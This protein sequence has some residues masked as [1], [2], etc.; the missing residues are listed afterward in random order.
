MSLSVL[1]NNAW[2]QAAQFKVTDL[3][4]VATSDTDASDNVVRGARHLGYAQIGTG[5]RRFAYVNKAGGMSADTMVLID[6]IKHA[7]H[8]INVKSWTAFPGTSSSHFSSTNWA[9]TLIGPNSRDVLM[10]IGAQSA[11]HGFGIELDSGTGGAYTKLVTK[12]FFGTLMPLNYNPQQSFESAPFWGTVV[13]RRQSYLVEYA[14]T[15][16]FE[17][18]TS[19]EFDAWQSLYK[20]LEEPFFLYDPDGTRLPEKL[21]HVV[22]PEFTATPLFNNLWNLQLTFYRLRTYAV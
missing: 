4:D 11:K 10:S 13:V 5:A 1:V 22:L 16:A 12:L 21:W 14:A 9:P 18:L 2:Q 3:S 20:L 19:V 15:L 6:A 17:H 8:S 7:T